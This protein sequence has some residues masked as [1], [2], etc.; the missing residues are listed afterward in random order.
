M[1]RV[2]TEQQL[3]ESGQIKYLCESILM[4]SLVRYLIVGKGCAKFSLGACTEE[5][6]IGVTCGAA[7]AVAE[8]STPAAASSADL[9]PIIQ[10]IDQDL[11]INLVSRLSKRLLYGTFVGIF[12]WTNNFRY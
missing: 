8:I 10:V 11:L 7:A 1:C 12:F 3:I 4:C 9:L 2:Q 6:T 5:S